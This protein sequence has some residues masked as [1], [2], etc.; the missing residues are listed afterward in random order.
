MNANNQVTIALGRHFNLLSEPVVLS[1]VG[2]PL[3]VRFMAANVQVR[4]G[5]EAPTA[6]ALQLQVYNKEG[7][8]LGTLAA[9]RI[10]WNWESPMEN[11]A[12]IERFML[13]QDLG[14]PIG[15]EGYRAIITTEKHLEED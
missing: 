14:E 12:E 10:S 3:R 13:K 6:G 4:V 1:K 2:E 15:S 8:Q 11:V 5:I 9:I 7:K